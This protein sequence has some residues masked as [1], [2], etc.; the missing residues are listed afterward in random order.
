MSKIVKIL[1]FVSQF[2]LI[3]LIPTVGLFFLGL[4]L[5]KKFGTSFLVIIFFFVGAAGGMTG[6]YKL[7]RSTFKDS[8]E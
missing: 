1:S 5:D 6:V 8:E 4:Y 2:T 3:M 7:V